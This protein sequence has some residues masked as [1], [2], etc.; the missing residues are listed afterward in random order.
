MHVIGEDV[1]ERLDVIPA[2]FRVVVTRRP[3]YGCRGC[4]SAIIQASVPARLIPGG[5][6]T[7]AT[8]AHVLTAKFADHCPLYRQTQI[9][10]RQ[11]IELDRST[12]ADWVGRAAFE[13]RPVFDCL[14]AE[15]KRSTKLFM[16]ETR[17]PVLDPGRRRT[18]TGYLWALA[19]D[20]RA[21]NDPGPPGVAYCYAPGRG[22]EHAEMF[23]EGFSGILQVDGYPGYNRLARSDRQ[24]GAIELAYC[25]RWPPGHRHF[26]KRMIRLLTDHGRMP[27]ASSMK[28]PKARQRPSPRR[29]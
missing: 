1:S 23:L 10:A 5:I 15:L 20:D 16:D 6:P 12:L 21:W 24:D 11:G 7:E 29:A 19:R 18:K 2:Q 17:A 22:G 25:P 8:V 28:S 13:L 14:L 4:E 26:M 27:D 3:K 9:Y